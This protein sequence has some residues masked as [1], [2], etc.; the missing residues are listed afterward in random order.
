L[1]ELGI[2]LSQESRKEKNTKTLKNNEL[3]FNSAVWKE[4]LIDG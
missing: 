3:E 1:K 2:D 4:V